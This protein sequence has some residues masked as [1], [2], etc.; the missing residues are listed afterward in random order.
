MPYTGFGAVAADLELDADVDLIVANGRVHVEAPRP[1]NLMPAPWSFFSEPNLVYLNNGDGSFE[2]ASDAFRTFCTPVEV[3][4]SLAAGDIDADGD[5]DLLVGN[6][7]GRARLYRN[8][9]P[10]K[11]HWLRLRVVDPRLNRV[12]IGAQVTVRLPDRS[13]VRPINRGFGYLSSGDP[14][15]HFGLGKA[16]RIDRIE[17]RWPDGRTESFPGGPADRALEIV[18]GEGQSGDG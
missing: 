18:R 11:G 12:A 16:E 13:L 6:V 10:R 2:P 7:Q 1:G 17:V 4:R 9:A 8:D 3:S 14:W 5:L 15:A